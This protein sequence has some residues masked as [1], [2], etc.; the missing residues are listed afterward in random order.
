MLKLYEN[1]KK[2]RTEKGLS[3]LELALLVGYKDASSIA[4]IEAG[5][6]DLPQSKIMDIANALGVPPG[7]LMGWN[8]EHDIAL[9]WDEKALLTNYRSLNVKAREMIR[10]LTADLKQIRRHT[11]D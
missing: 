2:V 10:E 7:D 3:Q 5:Q 11:V 4:K 6:N 1:I 9:S 8:E